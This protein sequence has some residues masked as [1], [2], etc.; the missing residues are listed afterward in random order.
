MKEFYWDDYKIE[1]VTRSMCKE[2]YQFSQS[3][4][5]LPFERIRLENTLSDEYLYKLLQR[6]ADYI[7]NI[8]EDAFVIDNC[9]LEAL[10]K[11]CIIEDIDVCGFPDGGVLPIRTHNPLV[12]NPFFNI[13]HIKKIKIDFSLHIVQTYREHKKEYEKHTPLHLIRSPYIYDSYEPYCPFFIWLSQ[14]YTVLY[15]NGETHQDGISTILK[16]QN[17][18]SILIHSWYSRYYGNNNYHTNRINRIIQ[19]STNLNK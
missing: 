10:V 3:T 15:L 12:V 7:I 14:K 6:D 13:F 17:N 8:D 9:K 19:E 16:D 2:L 18:H 1:I 4:I 11:Y 5:K